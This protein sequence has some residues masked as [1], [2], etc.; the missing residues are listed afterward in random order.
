MFSDLGTWRDPGA[1]IS[2][3]LKKE[4]FR[5]FVGLGFR[6]INQKIFGATLRVDYGVDVFNTNERGLVIGLG[7]YF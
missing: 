4:Q 6:I 5:H 7:Q 3:F 1:D 2:Q